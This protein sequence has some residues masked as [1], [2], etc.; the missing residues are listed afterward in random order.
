LKDD[1]DPVWRAEYNLMLY[2][3]FKSR[4]KYFSFD[5]EFLTVYWKIERGMKGWKF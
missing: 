5:G 1:G 3:F 2:S 4:K